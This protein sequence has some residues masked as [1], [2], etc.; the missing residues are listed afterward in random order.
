VIVLGFDGLDPTLVT[1]WMSEGQLPNLARLAAQ[2]SFLPLRSTNPATSPVA[3]STF[4]TGC[5]PGKTGLFDFT[6]TQPGSYEPKPA[7]FGV[8]A[9]G[10][11]AEEGRGW[12]PLA[13]VLAGSL[14]ASGAWYRRSGQS[15]SRRWLL[16]AGALAGLAGLLTGVGVDAC[17][18]EAGGG[19]AYA[20]ALRAD[21]FW[22]PL[23]AAG[24]RC[25]ALTV[26]ASFPAQP[27][28]NGRLLSGWPIPA[29]TGGRYFVYS[30]DRYDRGY[31]GVLEWVPLEV[32]RGAASAP[33]PEVDWGGAGGPRCRGARI[34]L[35]PDVES[36]G[37]VV[38]A[39]KTEV[40][41]APGQWS[42]WV[43]YRFQKGWRGHRLGLA[44]FYLVSG[45]APTTLLMLPV[46]YHPAEMPAGMS[47]SWPSEE[48]WELASETGIL[49]PG[50]EPEGATDAL[51]DEVIEDEAFL[52]LELESFQSRW[53][54][55]DGELGRPDWNCLAAVWTETDR[56][57]H[58]LWRHLDPTHPAHAGSTSPAADG[59]RQ[60]YEQADRVV[61]QVMD[62]YLRPCDVLMV[63]SDHGFASYRRAIDLNGWLAREGYLTYRADAEEGSRLGTDPGLRSRLGGHPR[64]PPWSGAPWSCQSGQRV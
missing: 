5:N 7:G 2:G 59:I 64:Q 48:A 16:G 34:H 54:L 62:R 60:L 26:P 32:S 51:V 9:E 17:L 27:F 29:A 35:R 53:R 45:F 52:E 12:G 14:V 37:V 6:G 47:I 11:G 23:G 8:V 4:M 24:R 57:Q 49:P 38:R 22:H 61:G 43:P 63:V 50:C 19:L 36:G 33:G 39:G 13:G 3:W 21:P 40:E 46:C 41:L 18:R 15:P 30:T 44:R 28:A 20:P 55:V 42:P 56:V 10:G 1:R 58:A 25:V 31:R